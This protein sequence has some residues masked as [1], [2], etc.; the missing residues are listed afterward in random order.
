MTPATPAVPAANVASGERFADRSE[1]VCA[2]RG[3]LAGSELNLLIVPRTI[4]HVWAPT[5][6][7][8]VSLGGD[9]SRREPLHLAESL[10]PRR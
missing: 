9:L 4:P 1:H 2:R 8:V 3:A 5:D 10:R 7:L 6:D